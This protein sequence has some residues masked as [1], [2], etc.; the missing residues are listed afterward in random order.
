MGRRLAAKTLLLGALCSS[1]SAFYLPGAA[2][3][4]YALGDQVP[5]FV[6]ALTPVIAAN[7]KLK[8]MMNYDYYNPQFHF[9][10]P[11]EGVKRQSESLGS[12]LF[13]DRIFNSPYKLYMG[14]NASC[15]ELCKSS[16]PPADAK[17]INERILEDQAINWLVDGL[18]AS[19]L[20]QDPKSG[21]IFYDMGFNLGN[22][23]DQYAEKPILN[24]HYDIK[25]EY[26]TKD[27]KNFRVV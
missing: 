5:V 18:P 10:V 9:C 8:S 1:A 12:I 20:K 22:D 24:N 11:D 19:E 21:D 4:D 23:D 14:K 27:E 7:A 13:G 2:P 6:N 17:F 3:K 16:V 15:T 26:H 25:M